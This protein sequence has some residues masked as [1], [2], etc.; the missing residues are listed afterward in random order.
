[1]ALRYR[2]SILGSLVCSL[3]VAVFW[4]INLGAVYPF[5]EV[6]L[7]NKTLQQWADERVASGSR[8]IERLEAQLESGVEPVGKDGAGAVADGNAAAMPLTDRQVH[9]I[10]T[11]IE[12]EQRRIAA[13]ESWQPWI[14]KY[15]PEDPYQTLLWIVGFL[16]VATFFRGL[17]LMGNMLLVARVGQ[18]TM[19]DLQNRVF[20]NVLDMELN[21]VG[22]EGTGDLVMRIRGETSVIGMA[23]TN[24]FGKTLRE[25]L[26][27]AACLA[28]AAWINWRLLLFSLLVAPAAI[29]LMLV[30]ARSAKRANRRASEESARLLDRL[31]Q[32]LT[33]LRVV[34]AFVMENHERNRFRVVAN[35]VYA[36]G[37]KISWYGA[38]ARVNNELLG[39]SII[40]LAVLAGGYLVLNQE[41]TLFGVRLS[42]TAMTFGEVMTF[43]AFMCGIADPLRKMADVFGSLQGGMV[44][45]DRVFPLIDQVPRVR[46]PATTRELPEGPLELQLQDVEFAYQPGRPVLRGVTLTVPAGSSLAI[47]G[48]NGCGKSSL[49]NL[50]PRFF[51]CDSGSIRIGGV[52][53]REVGLKQLRGR[54]GYVTQQTMLFN[55]S[56]AANISYGAPHATRLE[57]MAAAREAHAD[58]FISELDDQWDSQIGEHGGKLSG[59][60]RQRLTLARAILRNPDLLLLD[61]ATSQIDPQ[62]ERLIHQALAR[63]IRNRTTVI[64]THRMETLD[65]V[66]Q[67][68]VMDEGRVVDLG[69]HAELMSRCAIYRH[70]R[71]VRQKEA[72]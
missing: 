32:S 52:D 12:Q 13:T 60:Q 63:F 19:L 3:L 31:Y 47:V 10:R 50:I 44:A 71:E 69:T 27:M 61:E 21:E 16:L 45:A 1:M 46:Q 23:I 70:L 8:N 35:D 18:R 66:D 53:V 68:L 7:H 40:G 37:M 51:D 20:D 4:G 65:L 14:R 29:A 24:L 38:L 34:K 9:S 15:A 62:S 6:V 72:A 22:V 28:G 43:F 30:L 42:G 59:G 48:P 41:T 55:D 39:I 57:I 5:V 11:E 54:I 67:I 26:K 49:I 64:V 17:F 56:V 33:Y 25:P 58:R 2:W 36:R